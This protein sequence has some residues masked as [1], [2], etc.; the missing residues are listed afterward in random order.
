M[1][2]RVTGGK[3]AIIEGEY[4]NI[5]VTNPV[6]IAVAEALLKCNGM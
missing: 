1:V 3:I 5:K 4:G 2:Q 6:D